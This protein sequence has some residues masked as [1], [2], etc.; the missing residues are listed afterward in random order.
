M[1]RLEGEGGLVL[2][3]MSLLVDVDD[4]AG[5]DSGAMPEKKKK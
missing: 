2:I 1:F 5:G 3:L 4:G